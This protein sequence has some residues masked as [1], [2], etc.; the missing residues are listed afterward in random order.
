M[1]NDRQ[2]QL[3]QIITEESIETQEQLLDRLQARGIKSTQA[4]IS[5][6]IKELHLIKEPSGQISL[7]CI[8]APHEAE[9]CQPPAHHLP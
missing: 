4:T 5:R 6:D 7:C 9:F 8:C 3:L 2:N 1:K